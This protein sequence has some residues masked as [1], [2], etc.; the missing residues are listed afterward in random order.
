MKKILFILVMLFC[1][2][3]CTS[4]S[5]IQKCANADNGL[6]EESCRYLLR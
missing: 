5:D 6:S 4:E 3:A 2:A 1:L